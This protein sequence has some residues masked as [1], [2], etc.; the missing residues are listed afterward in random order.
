MANNFR[1]GKDFTTP[2]FPALA[3]HYFVSKDGDDLNAGTDPDLPKLTIQSALTACPDNGTIVVGPGMYDEFDLVDVGTGKTLQGD[4]LVYLEREFENLILTG[5]DLAIEN[6]TIGQ[7]DSFGINS[8][9]IRN[10]TVRIKTVDEAIDP[11][12]SVLVENNVY[13]NVTFNL[14]ANASPP[15]DII[16]DK[17]IF[18]NCVINY[19]NN[20]ITAI[21]NSHFSST[22]LLN[23]DQISD[24]DQF[25]FNNINCGVTMNSVLYN[26]LEA[27]KY[28]KGI[29]ESVALVVLNTDQ[30]IKL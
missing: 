30:A 29:F 26:S 19:G 11:L 16:V 17:C 18:I 27:V 2:G 1:Y 13:E 20:A 5:T 28:D 21:K 7:Y 14:A 15:A 6:F 4:G 3:N 12:A 9:A 24:S 22:C 25:T 23:L 8:G 10:S